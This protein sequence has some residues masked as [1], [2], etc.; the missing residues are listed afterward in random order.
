MIELDNG[1]IV[2]AGMCIFAFSMPF[3]YSFFVDRNKKD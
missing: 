3:L 1:P 2:L